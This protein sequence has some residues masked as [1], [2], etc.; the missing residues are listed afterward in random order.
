VQLCRLY[1]LLATGKI[2]NPKRSR[3]MLEILSRPGLH[4]MFVSVLETHV[5]SE[6]LFRKSGEWD[7]YFSDSV[8]VWDHDCRKYI[9]VA[10]I[11]DKDGEQILRDLVPVV[12][13]LLKPAQIEARSRQQIASPQSQAVVKQA[14]SSA[15]GN[16]CSAILKGLHGLM[17]SF[18][19]YP[20]DT[21]CK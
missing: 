5:P 19:S 14:D 18:P 8:L 21:Q 7:T 3:Q 4:D 9:L 6:R 15:L 1:Y 12:E 2:I 16:A 10:L 11:D 20:K 13:E 17:S